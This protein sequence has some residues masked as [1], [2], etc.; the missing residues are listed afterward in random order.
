MKQVI[1]RPVEGATDRMRRAL[2]KHGPLD[3][4][5]LEEMAQGRGQKSLEKQGHVTRIGERTIRHSSAHGAY[6]VLVWQITQTGVEYQKR[7]DEYLAKPPEERR[8]KKA[9]G[10]TKDGVHRAAMQGHDSTTEGFLRRAW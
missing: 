2:I 3:S 10:H 8:K 9:N 1:G 7:R 4:G 6:V 5:Q